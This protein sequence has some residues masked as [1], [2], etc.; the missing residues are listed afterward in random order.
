M[1]L[2]IKIDGETFIVNGHVESISR[3]GFDSVYSFYEIEIGKLY[4]NYNDISGH[5]Y[6]VNRLESELRDYLHLYSAVLN[7]YNKLLP[8]K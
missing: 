1:R 8:F 5:E 4:I 2:P 3:V 6:F 7:R